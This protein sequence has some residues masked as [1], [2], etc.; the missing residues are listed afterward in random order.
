MRQD[1]NTL[2]NVNAFLGK[3]QNAFLGSIGSRSKRN[4]V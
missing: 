1:F 3:Q 2:Q 4:Q